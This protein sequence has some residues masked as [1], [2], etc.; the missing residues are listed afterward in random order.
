MKKLFAIIIRRELSPRAPA[1]GATWKS[2]LIGGVGT[3]ANPLRRRWTLSRA[4]LAV[5]MTALALPHGA[6]GQEWR[7]ELSET[8][9]RPGGPT[10]TVVTA[11]ID[12][13][14]DAF[15]VAA[16]TFDVH[17]S[18][19]GW[20]GDQMALLR[21]PGQVAGEISGSSVLGIA[22]GQLAGGFLPDPGRIE[23]WR[24]TFE[25][26]D[27]SSAREIELRT[28]TGRLDVWLEEPVFGSAPR[29]TR[30]PAE[31]FAVIQV[32]PAPGIAGLV[33]AAVPIAARRRR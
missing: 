2:E 3:E 32:V 12:P 4:T 5:V 13:G 22:I 33:G 15:A 28:E 20:A 24:A 14:P 25:V 18:E 26:S 27:F 6:N 11:S 9:L 21:Y 30:I 17:A 10:A 16:A 7:L 1:Q 31:G 19:G 23:V 29:E 8:E